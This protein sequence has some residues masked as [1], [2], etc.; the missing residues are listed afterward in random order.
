MTEVI[1]V[2]IRIDL[3]TR[4]YRDHGFDVEEICLRLRYPE[5]SVNQTIQKYQLTKGKKTW[6]Y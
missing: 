4:M 3:V 2:H 5:E 1:S 6:Q